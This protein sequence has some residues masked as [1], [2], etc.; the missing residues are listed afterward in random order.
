MTKFAPVLVLTNT[1]HTHKPFAGPLFSLSWMQEP[2][3]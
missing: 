2:Y 1:V 3:L